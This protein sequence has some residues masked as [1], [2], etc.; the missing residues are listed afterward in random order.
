M[1]FSY[2][3][4]CSSRAGETGSCFR[5]IGFYDYVICGR[6]TNFGKTW[7]SLINGYSSTLI[8][9]WL[10]A[11]NSSIAGDNSTF[12]GNESFASK[13]ILSCIVRLPII[14]AGIQCWFDSGYIPIRCQWMGMGNRGSEYR[15]TG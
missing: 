13:S 2:N 8:P 15:A 14:L 9:D 12:V 5:V 4:I 7:F 3:E 1:L 10:T 11:Y 6:I